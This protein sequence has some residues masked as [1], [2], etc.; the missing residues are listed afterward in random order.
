MIVVIDYG[1]G[2][3]NSVR[4]AFA[5]IDVEATISSDLSTIRKASK[6]ILPGVGHFKKG[7]ENLS[8]RGLIDELNELALTKQLPILGICLGMQLLSS[9][10]EEGPAEGLNWIPG[11]TLRFSKAS[12]NGIG[13]SKLR[14]PHMGWNSI[15][16][17]RNNPLLSDIP[18]ETTQ[19]FVHTYYV[20]CQERSD[21][22]ATTSYGIDFDSVIQKDNIMGTQFHPEK[23]HKKGLQILRNFANL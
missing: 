10:S 1:M 15:A 20:K 11:Q 6:I 18:A 9:R 14:I 21:V 3:L 23:S 8:Q 12:F 17:Q 19:Y 5:R 13:S 22:L 2:N 4:K 16:I 7:M